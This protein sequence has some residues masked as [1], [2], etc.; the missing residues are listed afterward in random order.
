MGL[1]KAFN[2]YIDKRAELAVDNYITGRDLNEMV[3]LRDDVY[4]EQLYKVFYEGDAQNI[5]RFF[6]YRHPRFNDIAEMNNFYRVVSGNIPRLHYPLANII[7]KTMVNLIFNKPP[8]ITVNNEIDEE[9]NKCLEENDIKNLLQTAAEY[10]SYSGAVGFKFVIDGEFSKYPI[11]V[12]YP[13]EQI[14]VVEK[15]GRIVEVI[16][17]DV[18]FKDNKQYVLNT[19]CG[20]G[21]IKYKLMTAGEKPKEVSLSTLMATQDLHDI[22]F[23]AN[24]KQLHQLMAVYKENKVNGQS[25]Y[26][27]LLDDFAALDEVYSNMIDYIR[28]T[29]VKVYM[30]ESLM[31]QDVNTGE[32]YVKNEY[33]TAYVT[34]YDS[35]PAGTNIDAKRDIVDVQNSLNGYQNAF[36]NILYNAL[37]TAGLSPASIGLDSAGANSSA[38]A[39]NI[40][41]RVSLRTR[42]EKC[43]KWVTALKNI[44]E[45]LIELSTVNLT[46]DNASIK[47]FNG[48]INVEFSDYATPSFGEQVQDFNAAIDAGLITREMALRQLYPNKTQDEIELM[49]M[50]I[51][52]YMED[53]VEK[54]LKRDENATDLTNNQE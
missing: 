44:V 32:K 35:N 10:E 47:E 30:P 11:I 31:A 21:Y 14:D 36:N 28:K 12:P 20:Y 51:E 42:A 54:E 22:Y 50:D 23:T 16:F 43:D 38:E 27:N 1:V 48:D 24:G 7:T 41:E 25:D 26:Y 49:L 39:L 18:Y 29:K 3:W 5:Y 52:G 19:V 53:P 33:D 8:T 9:L 45:I 17:K 34:L 37:A 13:K 46:G 4:Y 40:R 15:Y 6:K 2:G